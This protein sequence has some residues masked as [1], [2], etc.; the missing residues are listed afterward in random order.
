MDLGPGEKM[1]APP[2]K[3]GGKHFIYIQEIRK[4]ESQLQSDLCFVRVN[5][6]S[7]QNIVLPRNTKNILNIVGPRAH[8]LTSGPR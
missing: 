2:R 3:G 4:T 8:L 7:R 6:Y 1:F 5:L